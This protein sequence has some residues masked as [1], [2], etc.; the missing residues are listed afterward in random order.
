ME[1]DGQKQ[2]PPLDQGITQMLRRELGL[3]AGPAAREGSG[4]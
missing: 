1:R 2:T 3:P 4:A